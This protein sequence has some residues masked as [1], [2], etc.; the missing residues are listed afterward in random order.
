[1]KRWKGYYYEEA[2]SLGG[3]IISDYR[4][5]G[6]EIGLPSTK[7]HGRGKTATGDGATAHRGTMEVVIEDE[8]VMVVIH[9]SKWP[10]WETRG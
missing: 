8:K 7:E 3:S 10:N 2:V 1:M 9:L 4:I 5:D 6:V